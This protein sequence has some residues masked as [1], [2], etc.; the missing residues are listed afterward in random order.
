MSDRHLIGLS[1]ERQK[2]SDV[3]PLLPAKGTVDSGTVRLTIS[4]I[5]ISWKG[6]NLDALVCMTSEPWTRSILHPADGHSDSGRNV[7]DV[8]SWNDSSPHESHEY[9]LTR[10]CG[11]TSD[12]RVVIP[13]TVMSLPSAAPLISRTA[14][15]AARMV[16]YGL[17][18][19]LL[20]G[21]N[22][23]EE[24]CQDASR[25]CGTRATTGGLLSGGKDGGLR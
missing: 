2:G 13:R 14:W 24:D 15:G 5:F 21:Q 18:Y 4:W 17:M 23:K 16:E 9:A 6:T 7:L 10:M 1:N 11:L 22:R 12:T 20:Q 3:S 19:R 8:I 25:V